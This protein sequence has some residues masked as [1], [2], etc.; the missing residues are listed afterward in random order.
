MKRSFCWIALTLAAVATVLMA[1]KVSV[2]YD[3]RADFARYKTYSWMEVKADPL[4][5]D[6]IRG[7]LDNE[8]TA[9]GWTRLPAGGDASVA[10]FGA[11]LEQPRIE[12]YYNDFG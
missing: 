8:L 12:T 6:R 11:T 9:K 7:A 4:W 1:A 2:D 3:H 5:T 10:A